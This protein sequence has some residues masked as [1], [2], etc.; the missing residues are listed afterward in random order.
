V[1][2]QPREIGAERRGGRADHFAAKATDCAGRAGEAQDAPGVGKRA[3]SEGLKRN[4]RGPTRQPTLGG[5]GAYKPTV[6]SRRVERESEGLVV[7]VKAW[8]TRWREG[9]LLWS[10]LRLGVS[11]RE[12][13]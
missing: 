11:A 4:R 3:R 12:C 5:S 9:A 13:R 8:R 7:P 1:N 10:W 2:L 6:K